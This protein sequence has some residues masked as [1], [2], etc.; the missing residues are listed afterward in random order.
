MVS[1]SLRVLSDGLNALD[2]V[3]SGLRA[4]VGKDNTEFHVP[5]F[6]I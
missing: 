2:D 6:L 5:A 4:N 1:E 3:L